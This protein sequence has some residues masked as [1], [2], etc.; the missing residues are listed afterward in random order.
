MTRF[1]PNGCTKDTA[2]LE[3]SPVA[4]APPVLSCP[5]VIVRFCDDLLTLPLREPRELEKVDV[6]VT[7]RSETITRDMARVIEPAA[8]L[9][10]SL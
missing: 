4:P 9:L 1:W 5:F 3:S 7:R 8:K 6:L 2:A 10:K